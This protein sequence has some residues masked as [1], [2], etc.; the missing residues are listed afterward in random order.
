L[1]EHSLALYANCTKNPCP[2]R[3]GGGR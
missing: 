3:N 1:Q 2:H